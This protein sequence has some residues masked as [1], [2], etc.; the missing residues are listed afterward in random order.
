MWKTPVHA[1]AVPITLPG[2]AQHPASALYPSNWISHSRWATAETAPTLDV[3]EGRFSAQRKNTQ[4]LFGL[5]LIILVWK[6]PCQA[7]LRSPVL[8]INRTVLAD[9]TVSSQDVDTTWKFSF[10]YILCAFWNTLPSVIWSLLPCRATSL[11]TTV[12]PTSIRTIDVTWSQETTASWTATGLHWR[13]NVWIFCY[14]G[15]EW[16]Q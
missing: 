12:Y 6:Y 1:T 15:T 2:T 3:H 7:S 9:A 16:F 14:Y 4:G 8:I 11:C 5:T 10:V 13:Y